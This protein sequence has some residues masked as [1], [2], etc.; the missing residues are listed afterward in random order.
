MNEILKFDIKSN[1]FFS[2]IPYIFSWIFAIVSGY[3][4]DKLIIK[5]IMSRTS[6]RKVFNGLGINYSITFNRFK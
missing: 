1:G 4:S 3:I 5:K 6:V 2:A